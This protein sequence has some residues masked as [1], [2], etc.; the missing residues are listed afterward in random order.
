M[1]H[2]VFS[3]REVTRTTL[4]KNNN[5]KLQH[6]KVIY[7][8]TKIKSKRKSSGEKTAALNLERRAPNYENL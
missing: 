1:V 6:A 4:S 5:L 3:L 2:N 7:I 8:R